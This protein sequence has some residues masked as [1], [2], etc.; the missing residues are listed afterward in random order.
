MALSRLPSFLL[1]LALPALF[2]LPAQAGAATAAATAPHTVPALQQW[3]AGTGS[4]TFAGGSRVVVDS[5]YAGQLD[6]TGQVFADDL[7]QLTGTTVGRTTAAAPQPGD[8]FLTL[9]SADT[10]PDAYSL[11]VGQAVTVRAAGDAGAFYGTRTVLQLLRQ[12]RTIPAGTAQDWSAYPE[13]GLMVDA[14]RKYFTVPWL[15]QQIKD[16][17]YAKMNY[18]HLHLSDTFGF[19]LESSTHP[20]VTSAQHYSKQEITDLIALG[21]RYHVTVVPEIDM[22]GHMNA[23][24]AAHPELRL[25]NKAGT[26]SNEFIDLANPASYTLIQDLINEYLPLFPAAY[27][28]LGA[29]EYV[30]DYSSYPQ[31]LTYARSHYGANATAKDVFYGFVNW[32]DGLVRD[33][34]KTMRMWNDG[35]KSGDGTITPNADI[36]VDYWYNYGLTPQQ[37]TAAGHTVMNSSWTPTY[38]VYGGAKPDTRYM[39]ESWNP[40][41]FQGG[42]TLTDPSRNRGSALH[43][44]CDNPGAETEQQTAAGILT[45]LRALAQQTWGSP[46]AVSTYAE[47]QTVV[48]AIGRAP[49]LPADTAA[50]DL[51]LGKPVTASSVETASFPASGAVDGSYGTRWSSAY[52]DPQWLQI[53]LGSTQQVGRVKLSW[54]AAYAKAFQIQFSDD[55]ASWTTAYSTT[56]GTGG[57]QDLAVTASGRY[58]RVYLTQRATTY[59]YSLW[60]V[61]AYP[62][63]SGPAGHT[64]V[65]TAASSG[66]AADVNGGSTAAGAS[67]IEYR[68]TGGTNQQWTFQD[69]GGGAYRLVSVK[70]GLCLDVTGSSTADN[71]QVIQWTC[72]G[73]A[74]QTWLLQPAAAGGFTLTAQHSGKLLTVGNGGSA[75]DTTPIVQSTAN[76][77]AY[78]RWQLT[79]I[80]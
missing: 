27:W 51:A 67:V 57:V 22:P 19:R 50:G 35:I 26:A 30:T 11:T 24:L 72:S 14:G 36:T 41:I 12:S 44:W 2:L 76:G 23:V 6:V 56:G 64:Y 75:A 78:Q 13:R 46:K 80:S 79:Q 71:A 45:P 37:L 25:V 66:S 70:S 32:A 47:F 16:L 34:G 68:T 63:G 59:G 58:L 8:L 4:Y 3:T 40:G 77:A 39:Y 69:A 20:E 61:E 53:D 42:A 49:G 60:E 38:Y 28:H 43:V 17:A 7:T 55:G 65:L 9:G 62:P 29:D 31:L 54:E 73:N 18:L 15:Q 1:F 10:R 74:N 5:A 21:A 48:A 52:S 33:G